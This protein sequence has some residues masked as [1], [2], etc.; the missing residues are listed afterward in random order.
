[1]KIQL[2][3]ILFVTM[4]VACGFGQA[5][6]SGKT[7]EPFQ[8]TIAVSKQQFIAGDPVELSVRLTN[9][10]NQELWKGGGAS[11]PKRGDTSYDYSCR[12]SMGNDVPRVKEDSEILDIGDPG[13]LK[14]G[15][16][17]ESM[18]VVSDVCNLSQPDVYEIQAT[19]R[20][21][22]DPEHRLIK[23]NKIT[24]TVVAKPEAAELK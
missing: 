2:S 10:S 9:T 1:M 6:E 17:H 20:N 11:A 15:E 19:H 4:S 7:N 12:D 23:S 18:V 16:S 22:G 8:L 14:P 21:P 24:V 3:L 5:T 13:K